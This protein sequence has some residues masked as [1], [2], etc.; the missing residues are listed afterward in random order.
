MRDRT[1]STMAKPSVS[2]ALASS[3]TTVMC[4]P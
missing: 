2:T 1:L 4:S 3:E